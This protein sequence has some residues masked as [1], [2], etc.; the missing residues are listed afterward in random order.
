MRKVVGRF[1]VILLLALYSLLMLGP[2]MFAQ[3]GPNP[4][5][6]RAQNFAVSPSLRDLVSLPSL[7]HDGV[8]QETSTENIPNYAGP[9]SR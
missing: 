4:I 7:V 6:R 1:V 9:G 3:E 2:P 5:V 8:R